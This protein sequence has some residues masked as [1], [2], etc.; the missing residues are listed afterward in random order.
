VQDTAGIL[1]VDGVILDKGT[2]IK[3]SRTVKIDNAFKKVHFSPEEV[4]NAN[5]QVIDDNSQVIAVAKPQILNGTAIPE[6]IVESE[7]VFIP[8]TKYA[9]EIHIGGKHYQSDFVTPVMT[10][11]IDEVTWR[12]NED[13]TLDILVSTHDPENKIVYYRWMFEEDWE[14]KA[15][16]FTP[17][18]FDLKTNQIYEQSLSGPNNR[19]YCW[20]SDKSKS[21]ILGTT[22]RLT[23]AKIENRIIHHFS[24]NNSRFSYLYSIVV[25]QHGINKEAYTYFANKQKN[26]EQ[27][28]GIFSLQPTELEGNL[29]CISHPEEPVIGYIYATREIVFSRIFIDMTSMKKSYIFDC[30]FIQ[31]CHISEFYRLFSKK[32]DWGLLSYDEISGECILVQRMCVDCTDHGGSKNKPNFWPNDHQ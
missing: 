31:S 22:D 12:N 21:L 5:V 24:S 14:I 20:A 16:L 2:T 8:G 11:D 15:P 3:L 10:P 13:F 1:V 29:T 25:R 6:Y 32:G 28:E 18:L 19:Y 9:L 27:S 7:I 4:I 17:F 26:L 30:S 23:E